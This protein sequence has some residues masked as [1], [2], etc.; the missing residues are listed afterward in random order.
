MSFDTL[1]ISGASSAGFVLLGKLTRLQI[2][3]ILDFSQIKTFAGTSIGAVICLLL[4]I[5]Y[6]PSQIVC[7][8]KQSSI[9]EELLNF[10]VV[11]IFQMK[12]LFSMQLLEN[13]LNKMIVAKVGKLPT[14][15][16]LNCNFLCAA[17]NLTENRLVYFNSIETPSMDA[18]KAVILSCAIPFL[19]EPCIFEDQRYIDGGI[20]DNFPI[21]KTFS[22]FSPQK[23]LGILCNK[24]THVDGTKLDV[25][26]LSDFTAVLFAS[27]SCYTTDQ[28]EELRNKI[29]M[30]IIKVES[31]IPF[32]DLNLNEQKIDLMFQQGFNF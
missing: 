31:S 26:Q 7:H 19:F 32:Y 8:L 20:L 27:S 2:D 28:I 22:L 1:I 24:K 17:F 12:G 25:W 18:K 9:W 29:Q 16:E 23:I 6:S 3:G 11:K 30:E 4:A 15:A 21:R 13:E 14:F 5:G 10:N